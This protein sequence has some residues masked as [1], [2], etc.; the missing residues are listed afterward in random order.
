MCSQ[1]PA[2]CGGSRKGS[3]LS[4][5]GRA[6]KRVFMFMKCLLCCVPGTM[7]GTFPTFSF[8]CH[9][10]KH[11]PW[12][13]GGSLNTSA[14]FY[15]FGNVGVPTGSKGWR[16]KQQQGMLHLA[17]RDQAPSPPPRSYVAMTRQRQ[18]FHRVLSIFPANAVC[19][20]PVPLKV[21]SVNLQRW[22]SREPHNA[23][24]R[25]PA[26]TVNSESWLISAHAQ[27]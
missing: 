4:A 7:L 10:L 18:D 27:P 21:W 25:A 3:S 13:G 5:R 19:T 24:S 16:R 12:D 14:A 20:V 8:N 23:D 22:N 17:Q 15:H 26:W 2:S 9:T 1:G 6:G 11:F